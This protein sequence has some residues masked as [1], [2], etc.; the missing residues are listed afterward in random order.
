MMIFVQ[1][2]ILP[3][4]ASHRLEQARMGDY[5]DNFDEA[6]GFAGMPEVPVPAAM[7]SEGSRPNDLLPSPAPDVEK[8]KKTFFGKIKGLFQRTKE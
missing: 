5:S 8:P 6:A 4:N 1:P 7:P 2:R 3:D